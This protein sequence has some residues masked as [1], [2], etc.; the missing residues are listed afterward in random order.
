MT[1]RSRK[2]RKRHKKTS[3]LRVTHLRSKTRNKAHARR[4]LRLLTSVKIKNS[5]N[6]REPVYQ[7]PVKR[8]KRK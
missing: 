7:L 8:R 5:N 3:R 4:A 1:M 2:R 6:L